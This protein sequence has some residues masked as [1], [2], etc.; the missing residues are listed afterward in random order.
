MGG[1]CTYTAQSI[2]NHSPPSYVGNNWSHVLLVLPLRLLLDLPMLSIAA[3]V[4]KRMMVTWQPVQLP[5]KGNMEGGSGP[6][7][8]LTV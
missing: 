1:R 6:F 7:S 3:T 8:Q 5:V 4:S 2:F